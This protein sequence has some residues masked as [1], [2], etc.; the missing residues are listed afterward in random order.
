MHYC[1]QVYYWGEWENE[2]YFSTVPQAIDLAK[3]YYNN[4]TWRVVDA[5]S[6]A[7]VHCSNIQDR[8]NQVT[9]EQIDIFY[10]IINRNVRQIRRLRN[11]GAA[12]RSSQDENDLYQILSTCNTS[13]LLKKYFKEKVNWEKEGF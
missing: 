11:L 1:L 6:N 4:S 13:T 12:Q 10:Y 2:G 7:M 3:E 8:I 5:Y 9:E